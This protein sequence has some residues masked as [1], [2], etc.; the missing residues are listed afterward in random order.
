[1]VFFS[2]DYSETL[3]L[4]EVELYAFIIIRLGSVVLKL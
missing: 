3:S 4:L 2:E 1:M